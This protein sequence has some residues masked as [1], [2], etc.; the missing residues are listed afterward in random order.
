MV[1][2]ILITGATGTIGSEVVRQLAQR[3]E[4]VRAL[5]RDPSKAKAQARARVPDGS[6]AGAEAAVE[7][8]R[9]DY[10]DPASVDAAMS[11]A[12]AVFLVG[13]LGPDDADRD[14]ALVEQARAAGVHRV[15]KLSAIGTGDPAVGRVGSWH[16]PGEQAVRESGLE[17]TVLRPSAFASNTLS[18]AEAIRAGEPVPNMTGDGLQ[19][20]IDPRDVS[21]VAVEA[22]LSARHAGHTYTLTGTEL[23]SVPD[24]A[25]VLADV[26]GRPVATEDL[27]PDESRARLTEWGMNTEYA[28]GVLAGS[29]YVRGG[30][31]AVVTE[32]VRQVLGRPPRTYREWAV[33]YRAA[34]GES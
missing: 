4:K 9:G 31:N 24:Q 5:T 26:L 28:E 3:G 29:A 14:R 1:P 17:W 21:E 30:R 33:D 7:V 27:T 11:G 34:F 12:S 13:V 22:L 18:W 6:G 16:L 10:L 20:V 32:E 2:M 15:V 23:L 19:G 8:V 25:A